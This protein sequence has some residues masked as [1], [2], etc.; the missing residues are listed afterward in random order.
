MDEDE[1]HSPGVGAVCRPLGA[2]WHREAWSQNKHSMSSRGGAFAV[3]VPL[4]LELTMMVA[5]QR[6]KSSPIGPALQFAGGSLQ[7]EEEV[8]VVVG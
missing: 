7:A 8:V 3:F 5:C 2:Q 1:E 6:N 4:T